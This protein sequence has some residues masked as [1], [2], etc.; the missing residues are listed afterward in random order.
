MRGGPQVGGVDD[1]K[2]WDDECAETLPVVAF[3]LVCEP[4][5]ENLKLKNHSAVSAC[6]YRLLVPR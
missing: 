2:T 3:D 5:S 1:V 6:E 4:T